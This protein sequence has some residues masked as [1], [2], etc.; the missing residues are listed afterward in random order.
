ML[1][2]LFHLGLGFFQF[3]D[4]RVNLLETLSVI[5]AI[6]FPVGHG[7]N[8]LQGVF[9]DVHWL[10]AID[11]LA[12]EGVASNGHWCFAARANADRVN[13]YAKCLRGLSGG[14]WRYLASVVLSVGHQNNNF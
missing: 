13:L 12:A 10:R 8:F 4:F 2:K 7:G 5:G 6:V 14:K 9:V 3:V 11:L 1:S